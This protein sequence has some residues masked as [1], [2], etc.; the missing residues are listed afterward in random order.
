MLQSTPPSAGKEAMHCSHIG[1]ALARISKR[2]HNR[3]PAGK[4]TLT[5]AS[6]APDSHA[7]TRL[8]KLGQVATFWASLSYF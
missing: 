3:Q 5:K 6:P 7:P 1:T 8:S 4:K 2:S